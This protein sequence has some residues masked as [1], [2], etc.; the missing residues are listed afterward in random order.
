MAKHE[1]AEDLLQEVNVI[2]SKAMQGG[3]GILRWG[4]CLA[5]ALYDVDPALSRRLTCS[6]SD[7]YYMDDR[8][9]AFYVWVRENYPQQTAGDSCR[10]VI[11]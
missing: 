3:N 8:V 9:D 4:Q 6:G 7:P 11:Q 10:Q 1:T 2:A 5:N